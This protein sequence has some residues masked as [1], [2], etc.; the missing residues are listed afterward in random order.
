[1]RINKNGSHHR[2]KYLHSLGL[3]HRDLKS[4][5]LL[6]TDDWHA[7]VADFGLSRMADKMMTRGVGTPIYT[8]PEALA[9]SNYTFKA[10]VYRL[11]FF[12][13]FL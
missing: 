8:A 11:L 13:F 4:G 1:M 10:D 5:N 7:K 6:V 2:M 12:F 9:S 3:I